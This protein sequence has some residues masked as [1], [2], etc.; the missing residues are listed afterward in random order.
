VFH[1]WAVEFICVFEVFAAKWNT[2]LRLH[3]HCWLGNVQ[4]AESGQPETAEIV[5]WVEGTPQRCC[6]WRSQVK[7]TDNRNLHKSDLFLFFWRPNFL[8]DDFYQP[9][10]F[11]WGKIQFFIWYSEVFGLLS[12]IE[13]SDF[14]EEC[15]RVIPGN[16][17]LEAI[18][19][20]T[21]EGK[22]EHY[23]THLSLVDGHC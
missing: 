16:H 8:Y 12:W 10:P 17:R 9:T 22:G 23:V 13:S 2:D 11:L 4:A 7:C 19:K 20:R 3:H 14:V 18:V 21:R 6:E 1:K 15:F 5:P